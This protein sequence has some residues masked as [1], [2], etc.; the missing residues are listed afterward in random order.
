MSRSS[1]CYRCVI[2]VFQAEPLSDA[3]YHWFR[4]FLRLFH[5]C[6]RTCSLALSVSELTCRVVASL[7]FAF[8][9]VG[10]SSQCYTLGLNVDHS[11]RSHWEIQADGVGPGASCIILYPFDLLIGYVR[12]FCHSSRWVSHCFH[13]P[14]TSL[15]MRGTPI[16]FGLS[17]SIKHYP[18]FCHVLTQYLPCPL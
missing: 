14:L 16:V 11:H 4:S 3:V 5:N 7:L 18:Q 1:T 10:L 17:T 2:R 6:E 9:K 12:F 15:D 8:F 13:L